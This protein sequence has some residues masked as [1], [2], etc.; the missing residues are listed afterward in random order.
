MRHQLDP[1]GDCI[2]CGQRDPGG[3]CSGPPLPPGLAPD[4][5]PNMELTELPPEPREDEER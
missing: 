3:Q 1:D 2:Q 5:L 4:G